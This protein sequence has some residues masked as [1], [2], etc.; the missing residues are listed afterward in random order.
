MKATLSPKSWWAEEEHFTFCI[1]IIITTSSSSKSCHHHKIVIVI[2][3]VIEIVIFCQSSHI[4]HWLAGERDKEEAAVF[5]EP[6]LKIW[7]K[8]QPLYYKSFVI[9]RPPFP[10]MRACPQFRKSG[11]A[12]TPT[13]DQCDFLTLQIS[14]NEGMPSIPEIWPAKHPLWKKRLFWGGKTQ[15]KLAKF[16][17]SSWMHIKNTFCKKIG[18][19]RP[20]QPSVVVRAIYISLFGVATAN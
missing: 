10:E 11:Q 7:F 14:R 13:W 9:N 15:K 18:S 3:I 1:R 17:C 6:N 20:F 12:G 2:E 19:K 5:F 8:S 4:H 16:F